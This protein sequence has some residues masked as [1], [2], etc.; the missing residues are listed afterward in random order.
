MQELAMKNNLFLQQR[1]STWGTRTPGDT[2]AA[3]GGKENIKFYTFGFSLN[4][5]S[6]FFCFVIQECRNTL[7]VDWVR[8][9]FLSFKIFWYEPFLIRK[10][11]DRHKW[12]AHCGDQSEYQLCYLYPVYFINYFNWDNFVNLYTHLVTVCPKKRTC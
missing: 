12:D 11:I 3:L 2:R 9:L 7:C 8:N 10:N 5:C 4:N 1:L 6:H